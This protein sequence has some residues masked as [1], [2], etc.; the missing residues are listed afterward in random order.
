M[1]IIIH[2]H[3][4]L[5]WIGP[6]FWPYAYG[7]FFYYALWPDSYWYYDPFW[8]YGYEDIYEG[9][10]FPYSY[11]EYVQGADASARM[12]TLTESVAQSCADET[13]EVTGWPI[14][15][16]QSVV[17]P[18]DEQSAFLDDLGNAIVKAGDEIR[19]HCPTNVSFT[20][21]RRLADMQERFEGMVRGVD[22]MLPPLTKFYDALTDEQKAR[23]NEIEIKQDTRRARPSE[24]AANAA[25]PQAE[26]GASVMAWPND[27]IERLVHP[28]DDQRA[29]L[30]ALQSAAA[31][32]ADIIKVACPSEVPAT[33]PGRLE[34][35]GKRLQA[36]L[37]AVQTIQPAL[38]DFY[39]SLNDDQKA[40][41]NTMG[42][43][44]F[45]Q[46]ER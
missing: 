3:H 26:C 10:F 21:T 40:R 42:R 41:F 45:A 32:A 18:N 19:S 1:G 28:N 4:H 24:P 43:R 9:I 39:N 11:E 6:L 31:Q 33:P 5:G 36:M 34:A 46:N 29:K 37:R 15:Q 44:L 20:P 17:R 23:F 13:A 12:R 16:I 2:H 22:I 25:T 30:D 7:D 8:N 14:N 27:Q 35:V 38:T